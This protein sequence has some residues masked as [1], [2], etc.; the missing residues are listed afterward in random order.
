MESVRGGSPGGADVGAVVGG[1]AGLE[2]LKR[3][4]FYM[5]EVICLWAHTG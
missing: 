1:V 2:S 3:R 5:L 4:T